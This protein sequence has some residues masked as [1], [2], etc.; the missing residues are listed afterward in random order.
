MYIDNTINMKTCVIFCSLVISIFCS[1]GGF[2]TLRKAEVSPKSQVGTSYTLDDLPYLDVNVIPRLSKLETSEFQVNRS[3]VIEYL[4]IYVAFTHAALGGEVKIPLYSINLKEGQK[5]SYDA[6]KIINKYP[7]IKDSRYQSFLNFHTIAIEKS[8]ANS[9]AE[10]L[11]QLEET[12]NNLA[13]SI[14]QNTP[15]S[16][17]VSALNFGTDLLN[18]FAPKREFNSYQ[19]VQILQP[20]NEGLYRVYVIVPTDRKGAVPTEVDSILTNTIYSISK[21]VNGDLYANNGNKR[22][23]ETFPYL[24]LDFNL[25][26]YVFDQDLFIKSDGTLALI[27]SNQIRQLAIKIQ[28][29]ERKLLLPEL[30]INELLSIEQQT[31][32]RAYFSR[33][34]LLLDIKR[35]ALVLKSETDSIK[36]DNAYL[37]ILNIYFQYNTE[38][39]LPDSSTRLFKEHYRQKYLDVDKAIAT[40]FRNNV[41][42]SNIIANQIVAI[43]TVQSGE[44]RIEDEESTNDLLNRLSY[45]E[46]IVKNYPWSRNSLLIDNSKNSYNQLND[47]IYFELFS[48]IIDEISLED[49]TPRSFQ[50]ISELNNLSIEYSKC[51]LCLA[52]LNKATIVHQN[53]CSN[54]IDSK[55]TEVYQEVIA[56][57]NNID[58]LQYEYNSK[59]KSMTVADQD[60]VYLLNKLKS[61][62]DEYLKS[63]PSIKALDKLEPKLVEYSK[64]VDQYNYL[65]SEIALRFSEVQRDEEA[66]VLLNGSKESLSIELAN[67]IQQIETEINL[68]QM[69]PDITIVNENAQDRLKL[70]ISELS[71]YFQKIEHATTTDELSILRSEIQALYN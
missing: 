21:N 31:Y 24:I 15:L 8:Y 71:I 67:K 45:F 39:I 1:C 32:E 69:N 18:K 56:L 66:V 14:V 34:R 52:Q 5:K 65:K 7:I 23:D 17:V 59:V 42:N 70:K 22:L 6:Y 53:K 29:A 33:L 41:A 60:K 50:I 61:D 47:E 49:C 35:H 12:D 54:K 43:L 19:Q 58:L 26:N 46:Q 63:M 27:D 55:K 30:E 13:T 11:E 16:G 25:S 10:V 36:R 40:I 68:L 51:A 28:I 44:Y 48:K 20:S 38:L 57:K 62:L 9:V 2:Y 3:S 37:S 4:V 64:F